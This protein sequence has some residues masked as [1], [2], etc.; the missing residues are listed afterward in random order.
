MPARVAE[1]DPDNIFLT[2]FRF[3]YK[4]ENIVVKYSRA[5]EELVEISSFGKRIPSDKEMLVEMSGFS[6]FV[7]VNNNQIILNRFFPYRFDIYDSDLNLLTEIERD[8]EEFT[9][10][11]RDMGMV[12]MNAVGREILMLKDFNMVRYLVKETNYFDFY[13]KNWNYKATFDKEELNI[14]ADGLFFS[15]IPESNTFIVL[16]RD[17]TITLKK[18]SIDQ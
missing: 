6:D 7:T 9:P 13:D 16:Y 17:D 8:N 11:V 10:P 1:F 2:G 12:R 4:D 18:Y 3:T 14:E 15:A 5:N